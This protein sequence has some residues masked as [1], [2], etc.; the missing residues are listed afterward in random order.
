MKILVTGADGFIGSHL[1]EKLVKQGHKVRAF[2]LYN[3]FNSWG[4]LDN[5]DIK[6]KNEIE[7][8]SGDIRD[9][10]F[11]LRNANNVEIIFHLASL[12]AIPYSYYSAL[13]Y[14][15]TNIIGVTNL[16]EASKKNK[17]L[18]QFVHTSTSEV[19]GTAESIPINEKHPLKGQSPYSATKI[20]ADQI[21][22]SYFSS[23]EIPITT[24][25]PFNTFG[26]R[27]SLRAVI[28]TIITQFLEKKKRINLG[29]LHPTRDF[30]VTGFNSVIGKYKS[31]GE[32]IN[33]GSGFEIS[34]FDLVNMIADIMEMDTKIELDKKRLRPKKSEVDR[35]LCDNTKAKK[36]LQWN[37]D[38]KGKK[39]LIKGLEKTIEWF[40]K[41]ENLKHYR[42]NLYNI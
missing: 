11:V 9:S 25:R 33:I 12:I 36:I 41:E 42:P 16:L 35:L 23:F 15:D 38:Y 29:S 22:F 13:S 26:P 17:K 7:V 6:I 19:Y 1:V 28:P 3:S 37:P 30:T 5:L 32:V 24:I 14:I 34:I 21:V 2:V 40:S 20:A 4:W 8:L 18:A 39:G 31:I 27:Q 10:H